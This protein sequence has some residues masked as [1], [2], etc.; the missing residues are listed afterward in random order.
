MIFS[1][2]SLVL[3]SRLKISPNC[4]EHA[5]EKI[6]QAVPGDMVVSYPKEDKGMIECIFDSK[7]AEPITMLVAVFHAMYSAGYEQHHYNAPGENGASYLVF[8]CK[9][10]Y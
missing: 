3:S 1:L 5:I 8:I 6:K 7:K 2:F 4:P 9:S 10:Y